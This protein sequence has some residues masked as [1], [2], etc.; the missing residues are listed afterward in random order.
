MN[1]VIFSI[2][3]NLLANKRL[4][5]EMLAEKYEVSTRTISR[6]IDVLVESGVPIL[7]IPGVGGGY[8]LPDDYKLERGF[9]SEAEIKRLNETLEKTAK[10]YDD[11]LNGIITEKLN[12]LD[13]KKDNI[14]IS[15]TGYLIIDD[16]PWSSHSLYKSKLDVLKKAIQN[17]NTVQIKYTDRHEAFTNRLIDPYYLVLK[18]Y[19]WY[20]YAYCHV[21]KDFRLFKLS[22]INHIYTTN[23]KFERRKDSNVIE[24]LNE[25]FDVSET[26][27]LLIEFSCTVL[28][29]IE[30]WLGSDA[31]FEY[32]LDYRASATVAGGNELLAKILSFGSSVKV[33]SPQSLKDDVIA[34]CNRVIKNI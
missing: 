18:E 12:A 30:E 24:K 9:L 28:P 33:L 31:V 10:D 7:S 26:V 20:I 27:N 4:T 19:V 34:E 15:S 2:L 13:E 17:G 16:G 22:R 6:Y 21:R 1:S 14:H 3:L 32:G 25:R 29:Q 5:R 8:T 23:E 11:K